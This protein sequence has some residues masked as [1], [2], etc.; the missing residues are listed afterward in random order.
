MGLYTPSM[1]AYWLDDSVTGFIKGQTF[2]QCHGGI[3]LLDAD[4]RLSSEYL[5]V[6]EATIATSLILTSE[7]PEEGLFIVT[8]GHPSIP[9]DIC[10]PK[11]LNIIST[12]LSLIPLYNQVHQYVHAFLQWNADLKEVI[13]QN[14]GLQTLLERASEMIPTTMVLVNAGFKHMASVYSE[15][16][17]DRTADELKGNGYQT[18]ETIQ[19]IQSEKILCSHHNGSFVEY[20]SSGDQNYTYVHL[21]RHQN[22]LVAR[23]C[24]IMN[25]PNRN[26]CYRDLSEILASYVSEYLLSNQGLDYGR[27]AA[28]G[29][30]VADLI[31]QRLTDQQE[32]NQRLKQIQL[33]IRHYYQIML[34]SFDGIQQNH[35]IPWNYVI[36]QLS[37]IFP[38][39]N[40]TT[41]KGDILL[42]IRK[43]KRGTHLDFNESQLIELL[44]NYKG[45]A[46]IGNA[47]EHLTSLPPT[48]FQVKEALRLGSVMH[49]ENRILYYEEY[50]M[51]HMVELAAASSFDKLGSRNLVHLCNN[52][53]IAIL[54]YDQKNGTNFADELFT[55]LMNERNTAGTARSLYV[56]RNTMLYKIRKM[57]SII[58]S[59]L[60]NPEL[61]ERLIFSH[62]VWEYATR[63]LKEDILNLKRITDTPETKKEE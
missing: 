1:L 24:V 21:I 37:Y 45:Y 40:I 14:S 29:S 7:I 39:S 6:G 28:F 56:H 62:Y 49:P 50:S 18:F 44:N 5:Y 12:H 61:R 58:G 16:V 22:N 51:F 42:L 9:E 26:G 47:S 34:I 59:S 11:K 35:D 63:Y 25:G 55:Y 19:I 13:Y 48:Y 53:F 10:L 36:N 46:A 31:E 2:P 4:S 54:I 43:I 3:K 20:I 60:E 15:S 41:Y 52:E 32:L 57:E 17:H 30:L 38:F 8:S 33:A 27:N 23:L